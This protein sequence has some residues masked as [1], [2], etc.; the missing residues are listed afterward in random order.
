MNNRTIH[1]LF[2]KLQQ[3]IPE[4]VTELSHRNHFEL[5]IAVILSAQATDKSVNHVTPHLFA[6]YPTPLALAEANEAAVLAM[7]K[8]IGLA[9]TKAKNIVKTSQVLVEK[10][11]S[12]VPQGRED[13]EALPGVGR[14]TANVMLNTAFGHPVIAVDTHV[15]RVANRTG[16]ATG[17]TPE[18]IET[19][20][21]AV[22]PKKW[23]KDAH[24][25]LV[26]HGRYMCKAKKPNCGQCPIVKECEFLEKEG[27]KNTKR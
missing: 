15:L 23:K 13:L 16:L 18:Q 11:N 6:Q 20:L 22:V 10:H 24:H 26:L 12:E 9:K 27:V 4:P 17:K 21:M 25:F 8:T 2:E 7:I 5:L 3:A 14:K 1:R 19:Q